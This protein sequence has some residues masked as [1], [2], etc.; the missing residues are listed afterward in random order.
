MNMRMK[1][2]CLSGLLVTGF[3]S[4]RAMSTSCGIPAV[5]IE[6]ALKAKAALTPTQYLM[7]SYYKCYF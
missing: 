4:S 6:A 3:E 5:S 1:S 2:V 7:Y